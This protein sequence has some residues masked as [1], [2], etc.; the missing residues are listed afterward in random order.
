[1]RSL[2]ATV[3]AGSVYRISFDWEISHYVKA[4]LFLV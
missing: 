3:A 1:M 2:L 4:D